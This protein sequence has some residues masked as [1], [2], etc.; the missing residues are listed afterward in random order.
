[1]L[2]DDSIYIVLTAEN[3]AMSKLPIL[4][5][6]NAYIAIAEDEKSFLAT[7]LR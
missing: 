4:G 1:M 7:R 3:G 5:I 2:K 6:A